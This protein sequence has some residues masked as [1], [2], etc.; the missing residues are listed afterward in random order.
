[1]R[2][3][4]SAVGADSC[5]LDAFRYAQRGWP[6]LP[7]WW[8]LA[9]RDCACG[10]A[11]CSRPGKHPIVRRGLHAATLDTDLIWRWWKRWPRANVAIRTGAASGLLVVDVDGE[12]GRESL[13]SLSSEHGPIHAAWVRSGSG[14]WHAYLRMPTGVE[15]RNSA[16][17]LGAGL[18]VRAEGGAITAPP[19]LHASGGRYTWFKPGVAPP[20]AP[21][22]LVQLALPPEPSVVP[23]TGG[24]RQLG[25]GYAAAAIR[26]EA[27]AV[28]GAPA[29]T[30]NDRLNLA[31]W[32]LGRLAAAGVVDEAI[33]RDALL[34]ASA[35][36]GLPLR[37][38]VA[39][40]RSGMIAGRRSPRHPQALA[41][42][43]ATNPRHSSRP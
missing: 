36:C 34:T 42:T 18:D 33:A 11:D 23:A 5:L 19:S 43:S 28:A 6:V 22:W 25:Q 21:D 15:V 40:V 26:G 7:V 4:F 35:E 20:E 12:A 27:E 2:E 37:E 31:A 17:R 38:S 39:T 16:G 13:R 29:G 3:P 8:P 41:A 30:R 24:Y 1:L 10:R 14:G 32:R 9:G